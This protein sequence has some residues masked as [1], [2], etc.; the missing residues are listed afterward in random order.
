M[1]GQRSSLV[2]YKSANGQTKLD[3]LAAIMKVQEY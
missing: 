1:Q 3:T 2:K